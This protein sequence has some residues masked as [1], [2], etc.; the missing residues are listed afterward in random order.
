MKKT[1]LP[2]TVILIVVLSFY[3]LMLLFCRLFELCFELTHPLAL[4]LPTVFL[5]LAVLA[6]AAKERKAGHA[7]AV[8]L[9]VS[10]I[11]SQIDFL[12]VLLNRE[13]N[14]LWDVLLHGIAV[15]CC[16][17]AGF[18]F[19]KPKALKIIGVI[20]AVVLLILMFLAGW[21]FILMR[22]FGN[23]SSVQS[24]D[25]PSGAFYA[26]LINDNQGALGGSTK[27]IVYQKKV[28]NGGF[29]KLDRH[30]AVYHGK[31]GEFETLQMRW[32]DDS[33]LIINGKPYDNPLCD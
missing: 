17:S 11:L 26:E 4:S 23:V 6:V 22:D 16:L 9:A 2:L 24:L 25:S 8:L 18:A 20:L 28:F 10:M 29:F 13:D 33:T 7:A 31:W 30:S 32:K 1:L 5:A 27:V 21:M 19:G 14:S 15:F 3:P 12:C